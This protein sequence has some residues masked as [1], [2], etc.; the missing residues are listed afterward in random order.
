MN[1]NLVTYLQVNIHTNTHQDNTAHADHSPIHPS[2]SN[3]AAR[4]GARGGRVSVG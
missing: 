1:Y 4:G 2:H 3:C